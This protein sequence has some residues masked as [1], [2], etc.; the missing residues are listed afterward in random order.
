[1]APGANITNIFFQMT[2]QKDKLTQ[3]SFPVHTK[4]ADIFII[5]IYRAKGDTHAFEFHNTQF[6]SDPVI[7]RQFLVLFWFFV[8]LKLM[9]LSN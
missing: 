7:V 9:L 8:I 1:M 6:L 4:K 3:L 2:S 5:C